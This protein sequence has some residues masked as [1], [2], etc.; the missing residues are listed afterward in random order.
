MKEVFLYELYIVTYLHNY[1]IMHNIKYLFS[2]KI[3]RQFRGANF[4]SKEDKL[5]KVLFFKI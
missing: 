4:F 2:I 5:L 1:F 3:I